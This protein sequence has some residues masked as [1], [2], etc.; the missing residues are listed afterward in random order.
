MHRV[1]CARGC[2]GARGS[3]QGRT[4]DAEPNFLALHRASSQLAGRSR[5]DAFEPGQQC[6]GGDPE[7][8]HDRENRIALA[9]VANHPT[10]RARQGERNGEHQN[11]LKQARPGQRILERVRRVGVEE[12]ATV[13]ADLLDGLLGCHRAARDD[14]VCAG[15]RRVVL[16]RIEVLN[17][18]GDD[19]NHRGNNRQRQENT[20]DSA[21]D[22]HPEVS[23][24]QRLA[25]REPAYQGDRDRDSHGGRREVLYGEPR[26]LDRVTHRELRRIRLPVGV[27]DK[28]DRRVPRESLLH[29]RQAEG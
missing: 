10:E 17:H 6:G 8:A 1:D 20:Q 9:I 25:T 16:E 7:Q 2:E 4:D 13:R 14:R 15:D 28:G 22:I 23:D 21:G 11:D 5:P 24:G 27:G 19:Q 12:S 3:E 29:R 26:D 18:A